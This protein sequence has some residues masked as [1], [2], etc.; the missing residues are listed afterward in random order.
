M[1]LRHVGVAPVTRLQREHGRR[2]V[3][4]A[5]PAALLLVDPGG[6]FRPTILEALV[7]AE[8]GSRTEVVDRMRFTNIAQQSNSL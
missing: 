3:L 5:E 4:L 2:E 7:A 1:A 6:V 8:R